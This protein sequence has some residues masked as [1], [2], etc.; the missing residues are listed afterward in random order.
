ME[1][2]NSQDFTQE[3]N[4][5]ESLITENATEKLF[6]VTGRKRCCDEIQKRIITLLEK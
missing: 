3:L 1:N 6:H 5:E 4:P 2:V